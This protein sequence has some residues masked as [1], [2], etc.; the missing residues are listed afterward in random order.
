MA[1]VVRAAVAWSAAAWSETEVAT[2]A[3]VVKAVEAVA[4]MAAAMALVREGTAREAAEKALG[5][6][7]SSRR[8]GC[9]NCNPRL[10][11]SVCRALGS[12]RRTAPLSGRR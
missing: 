6:A 9:Y 8:G 3:V 5:M 4:M 10:R 12:A 2:K 11:S 1:A 7:D